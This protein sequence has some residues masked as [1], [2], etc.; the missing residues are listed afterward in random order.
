MSL[1]KAIKNLRFDKRMT[2]IHVNRGVLTKAEFDKHLADLPDL[3]HNVELASDDESD[4]DFETEVT[5]EN[6]H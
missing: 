4:E 3:A 2:E 5:A 1:D 6:A